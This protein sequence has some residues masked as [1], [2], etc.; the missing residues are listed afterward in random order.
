MQ[1]APLEAYTKTENVLGAR[2]ELFIENQV[3]VTR[4][5]AVTRTSVE[6]FVKNAPAVQ[7]ASNAYTLLI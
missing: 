4:T 5:E 2:K 3:Q 7:I 1:D 6:T